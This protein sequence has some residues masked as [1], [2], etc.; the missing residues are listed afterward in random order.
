MPATVKTLHQHQKKCPIFA[1]W[2]RPEPKAIRQQRVQVDV[3]QDSTQ[4]DE[5]RIAVPDKNKY[6]NRIPKV[7]SRKQAVIVLAYQRDSA[8]KTV[9]DNTSN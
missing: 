7:C 2:P 4:K 1:H 5:A 8:F 3:Y 6:N 9:I